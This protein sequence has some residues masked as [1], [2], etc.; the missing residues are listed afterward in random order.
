MS[1]TTQ[2]R[3]RFDAGRPLGAVMLAI[4][5]SEDPSFLKGE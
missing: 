2:A 4:W 1:L 5:Q 3:L